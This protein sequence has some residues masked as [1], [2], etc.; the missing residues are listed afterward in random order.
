M[1]ASHPRNHAARVDQLRALEDAG[2]VRF[3][4]SRPPDGTRRWEYVVEVAGDGGPRTVPT[5]QI[6]TFLTTFQ[7]A[8]AA[9]AATRHPDQNTGTCHK[10]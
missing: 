7:L 6:D 2:L 4:E 1:P 3:I 8:L 5:S 10:L 9:C